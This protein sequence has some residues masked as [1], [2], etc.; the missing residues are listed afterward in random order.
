M[1]SIIQVN[2]FVVIIR[3][4][5]TNLLSQRR[6]KRLLDMLLTTWKFYCVC[7]QA[8]CSRERGGHYANV[9]LRDVQP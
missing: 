7:G 1:V 2:K 5:K 8:R 9:L 4:D 6:I 3:C